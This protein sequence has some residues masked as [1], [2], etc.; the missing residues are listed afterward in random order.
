MLQ[1]AP[2]IAS[3]YRSAQAEPSEPLR[4][5]LATPIPR[6]STRYWHQVAFSIALVCGPCGPS[7]KT[8]I[9]GQ[10][11]KTARLPVARAW[12]VAPTIAVDCASSRV[13]G[14][15]GRQHVLHKSRRQLAFGVADGPSANAPWTNHMFN[16]RIKNPH[17]PVRGST[18]SCTFCLDKSWETAKVVWMAATIHN[19]PSV[20]ASVLECLSKFRQLALERK[21]IEGWNDRCHSALNGEA[22]HAV[23]LAVPL[24]VRRQFGAFFTGVALSDRLAAHL[25]PPAPQDFFYDPTCGMG[26]LL[27]AVAKKLPLQKTLAQTLKAWGKQLAGT[28]LHPEFI[29]GTKTRLVL[30]ARYRHGWRAVPRASF[31]NHFPHI[32][33]GDGL[34]QNRLFRRATHL[35]MN[36]PYGKVP[37]PSGCKWAGGQITEAATFMVTALERVTPPT[38]ILAILPDVLRSGS[39]CKAWRNAISDLA[40]VRLVETYGVFDDHADVDVFLLRV[41]RR[42]EK[43]SQQQNRW[44]SPNPVAE[45]TV[46]E[47]FDVNVG[48]VVPHRDPQTGPHYLYL[49]PRGVPPWG[50]MREVPE[51]RQF[52]GKVF[53]PPFVVIRRTSRPGHPYRATAT[54][55]D[56]TRPVAVEN[57]LIVCT[58]KDGQLTLC[59]SLMEH[60]KTE[61]VNTF[62]D[63][64]IRCRHLTVPAVRG[65]PW[66]QP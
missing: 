36:P 4:W 8:G 13:V 19:P 63:N 41:L 58:P 26:D 7:W 12:K 17:R 56:S 35:L 32:H 29:Q 39:F 50:T 3:T 52:Q 27:L 54:I 24:D 55:V 66:N 14:R 10:L 9:Y 47:F 25:A 64:Q 53:R 23:R 57:H 46:G 1:S 5:K 34:A 40:E 22:A 15:R 48:R 11:A 21:Q 6:R 31:L 42:Q 33:V 49:H 30:L 61:A 37:A 44:P 16:H 2:L 18:E 60:L 51:T 62:L 45:S 43:E 20:F 38:E 65:V 28:D 59:R